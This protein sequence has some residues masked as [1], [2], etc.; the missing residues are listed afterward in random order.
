MHLTAFRR[1]AVLIAGRNIFVQLHH[2]LNTVKVNFF[3]AFRH[4]GNKE[5]RGQQ[6]QRN[7]RGNDQRDGHGDVLPQPAQ[8]LTENECKSHE[9]YF[10]LVASALV[11]V[12]RR[13]RRGLRRGLVCQA[14]AR[15][16][17]VA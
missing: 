6:G 9:M 15:S 5:T 7:G 13:T 14:Q 16:R 8:A 1:G 3:S 4:T 17:G 11:S 12:R 2:D 10:L